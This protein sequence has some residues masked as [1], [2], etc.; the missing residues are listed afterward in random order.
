MRGKWF[1]TLFLHVEAAI[2]IPAIINAV[3]SGTNVLPVP[4]E[5]PAVV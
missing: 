1:F 5:L 3:G 4:V 2:A